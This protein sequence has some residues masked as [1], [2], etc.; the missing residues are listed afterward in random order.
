[1]ETRVS[2]DM[3]AFKVGAREG[4]TEIRRERG[5]VK[6]IWKPVIPLTWMPFKLV[7][8]SEVKMMT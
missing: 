2:F 4:L 8:G 1:M 5:P 3:G 6:G 7:A